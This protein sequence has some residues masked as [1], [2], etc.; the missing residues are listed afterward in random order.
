M[1]RFFRSHPPRTRAFHHLLLAA[2]AGFWLTAAC[3][4]ADN[5]AAPEN[6]GAA[7]DKFSPE[8]EKSL[9][10]F[11]Q[12][13][14]VAKRKAWGT[15]MSKV[16][17]ELK[18]VTGLNDE[19]AKPL[20]AAIQA[21]IDPG[22]DQ[23]AKAMDSVYRK[24]FRR[25]PQQIPFI[26]KQWRDNVD[27]IIAGSGSLTGVVEP[28]EQSSWSDTLQ[29]VLSAS[30]LAAWQ[31][32]LADRRDATLK[33]MAGPLNTGNARMKNS[34][35]EAMEKKIA[36]IELALTP[37][38]KE[39]SEA[40]KALSKEAVG[41]TMEEWQKSA[42]KY[43]LS[44]PETQRMQILKQRAF[45]FNNEEAVA[46]EKQSVWRDGLAKILSAQDQQKLKDAE[47]S[48][49]ERLG[50]ML[51]R[52]LIS[53]MDNSCAFTAAQR[54]KLKP[55]AEQL[56]KGEPSLLTAEE[57]S[58]FENGAFNG[59][60]LAEMKATEK[61]LSPILE[62]SQCKHWQS[63]CSS[64]QSN[65]FEDDSENEEATEIDQATLPKTPEPED[66][67]HAVSD[68]LATIFASSRKAELDARML[69]VEDISRI[70]SLAP[71]TLDRLQTAARGAAERALEEWSGSLA[72][73]FRA[74]AGNLT[75][76]N[77]KQRLASVGQQYGFQRYAGTNLSTQAVWDD[78]VKTEL[79]EEQQAAWKK[80]LDA[81]DAYS[82]ET[83]VIA[84]M[85]NFSEFTT[86][87]PEQRDKLQ[88]LLAKTIHEY[89]PDLKNWYSNSTTWYMSY[90]R[91][92]MI[93]AI[94]EK[95]LNE[96]LTKEQSDRW[97]GSNEFSWANSNWNMLRQ[98]HEQRVKAEKKQ[99]G[100]AEKK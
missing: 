46:P 52:V 60:R 42:E 28:D 97:K 68:Y 74:N 38:S 8:I 56:V 26:I 3:S 76:K 33:Q 9:A 94:P 92:V 24:Q 66:V 59:L 72:E 58:L 41:K 13:V 36:G 89:L 43:V 77:I 45:Y 65:P 81:R 91:Y 55:L 64:L 14:T 69:R 85:E 30:Q 7:E 20:Q 93:L 80:E 67:E 16:I 1:L 78:A 34:Y 10:D 83:S 90:Y 11:T 75:A 54:E 17:E 48:R 29:R 71:A 82:E 57:S 6:N 23:F 84:L 40:L 32:T 39:S 25:N 31:K 100:E 51:G 27:A 18:Q 95:D 4:A 61:Q 96:I 70:N 19:G 2:L 73:N 37:L 12:K 62:A 44:L 15:K 5:A 53:T 98:N 22:A 87:K 49:T 21:A 99:S 86:L 50:S 88:P 35:E 79:K 47:N 63:A